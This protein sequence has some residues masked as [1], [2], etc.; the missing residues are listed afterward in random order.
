[1]VGDIG[2][3]E[4]WAMCRS[5][6]VIS[7]VDKEVETCLV[8]FVGSYVSDVPVKFDGSTLIL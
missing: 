1:M 2:E 6:T 8:A 5:C 7:G 4:A 3:L